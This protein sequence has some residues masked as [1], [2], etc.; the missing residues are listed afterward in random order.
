MP[1][2][3]IQRFAEWPLQRILMTAAKSSEGLVFCWPTN[4]PV[5]IQVEYH[6]NTT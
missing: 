6:E 3:K 2:V 5:P 4:E 1:Q